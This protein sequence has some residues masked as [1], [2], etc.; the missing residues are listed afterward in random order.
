[1]SEAYAALLGRTR[2]WFDEA[3]GAGWLTDED[4][5]RLATVEART[6]GDLFADQQARPLVVA[7]FGGTG[8]GKS[9][10]LNRLA[11]QEIARTGVERPTSREVTLYLHNSVELGNLPEELPLENVAVRQHANPEY[12]EILWLDAPDID[13]VEEVN[14]Q[15]ALAWLPHVDLVCYVV[16]PERYRDDVGW[17]VLKKRG[18]RHGWLF[19]LNRSDEGDP[20]QRADFARMLRSAGFDDPVLLTT[21]C[22]S[23]GSGGD[24]Q[25][26][27]L[28]AFLTALVD[29]HGVKELERLG[30]R[31]RLQDLRR[32]L[33]EAHQHVGDAEMWEQ[34]R[35]R[36]KE[37]W[38]HAADTI[39]EGA[40]WA[41]QAIAGRFA[42][43]T[44]GLWS[45]IRR[46]LGQKGAS[47]DVE[48]QASARTDLGL[49]DELI[50]RLWDGW[51]QSK[52]QTCVDDLEVHVRRAGVVSEPLAQRLGRFAEEAGA[53][54]TARLQDELRLALARPGSA[55]TRAVRR[56]MG[57][58]MA[59]LPSI[60]LLWVAY[61]VV[62]GFH[63]AVEG[64][65]AYLGMP[66]AIHA[67]LV[68][69]ISWGIPFAVD[70]WLRP[71]VENTV[72][73]ALR[74]GLA[75]GLAELGVVLGD[76]IDALIR[77]AENRRERLQG[78]RKE[79]AGMLVRPV[80]TRSAS[81]SRILAGATESQGGQKVKG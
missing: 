6:P 45:E 5:A 54:V 16:S 80:D 8:V 47:G 48:P 55:A 44:A 4:V 15:T 69:G 19:V 10:L 18:H 76:E 73:R 61:A 28:R 59:F 20:S 42:S 66:F 27:E 74:A 34:V 7:L 53:R 58:L 41:I 29:A 17:R 9:S 12:R 35:E 23:N 31:A 32:V 1:M 49:I 62:R 77:E 52:V 60:A 13:S 79:V 51:S 75:A 78:L 11:G 72:R 21:S 65:Q 68:V 39:A 64:G 30:Q 36:T 57:F 25:F 26:G 40:E 43:D 2:A 50:G 33:H 63:G 70:R 71:S 56:V 38:T 37:R 14:R 22:R 24:G 67:L 46:R 3:R 81:V